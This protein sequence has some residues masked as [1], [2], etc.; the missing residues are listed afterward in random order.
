VFGWIGTVV[1]VGLFGPLLVGWLTDVTGSYTTPF[2]LCT[3]IC[4]V[5]SVASFLCVVPWPAEIPT[6]AEVSTSP[7]TV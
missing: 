4:L 2:E 7:S 5:G 1:T 3:L 6:M